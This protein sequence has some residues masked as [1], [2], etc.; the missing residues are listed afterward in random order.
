MPDEDK[1]FRGSIILDF[2]I[3]RRHVKTIYN[4]TWACNLRDLHELELGPAIWS[5]DTGHL[6]LTA[7][8]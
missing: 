2:G 4:L 8:S 7:D 5:R 6:V 3:W 1:N